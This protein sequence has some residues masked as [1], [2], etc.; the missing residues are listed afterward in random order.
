MRFIG[1][2]VSPVDVVMDAGQENGGDNSGA[3]PMELLL[4]GVAAC[5]SM[6]IIQILS[7]RR[8]EL[9]DYWVEIDGARKDEHPR[10]FDTIHLVFHLESDE[11]T[12]KEV[13]RAIELSKDKYCS[14]WAN[15]SGKTE[16]SFDYKIHKE[17]N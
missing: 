11:L 4:M 16:I 5:A 17:S 2:G 15:L 9:R 1:E 12:D 14:A 3:R 10:Y 7:K 6:D 8:K 13:K